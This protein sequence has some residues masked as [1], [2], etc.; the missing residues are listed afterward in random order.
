MEEAERLCDELVVVDHGRILDHG[1]PRELIAR[2]VEPEVIEV[3]GG[4][5]RV[6]GWPEVQALRNERMGTSLYCYARDPGPLLNRLRDT[7]GIVFLHRPAGLEDVFLGLTGR[8][9][10]D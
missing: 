7:H 3:R 8:E 9:L 6:T 4:A 10:R 1:S 2:H 5:N